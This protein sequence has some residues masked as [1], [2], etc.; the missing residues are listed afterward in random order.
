V[1]ASLIIAIVLAMA[2]AVTLLAGVEHGPDL[3]RPPAGGHMAPV[4]SGP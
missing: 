1:K 3:H 2:F 4:E